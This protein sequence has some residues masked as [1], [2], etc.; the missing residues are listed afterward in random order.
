LKIELSGEV[1]KSS[2]FFNFFSSSFLDYRAKFYLEV[3][4][5]KFTTCL[6]MLGREVKISL[7]DIYPFF[8]DYLGDLLV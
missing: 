5:E 2:D 4:V 3:L 1:S 6:L 7:I 8:V